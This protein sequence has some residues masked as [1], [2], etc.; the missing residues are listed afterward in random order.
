MAGPAPAAAPE[1]TPAPAPAPARAPAAPA[2]RPKPAPNAAPGNQA[3]QAPAP[4]VALAPVAL[5]GVSDFAPS[6]EV[7]DAITATRSRG[8]P[9]P[10]RLGALAHGDLRVRAAGPSWETTGGTQALTLEHPALAT[11]RAAGLDPVL[12]VRVQRGTVSGYASLRKGDKVLGDPSALTSWI[13][14]HPAELGWVGLTDLRV[15]KVVNTFEGGQLSVRVDELAF[16]LGGYLKGTAAFGLT[17]DGLSLAGS[18][19]LKVGGLAEADLVI[20]R[21][22]AGVL[23]GRI[24]VPVTIAK[25]SGNVVAVFAGGVVDVSGTARYQTEKLSG[26][27]NLV[28]TDQES[29]RT[30]ALRKLDPAT[31]APPGAP[32][33]PAPAAAPEGPRP[34]PRALAGWGEL[35]F[36][37]TE[38]LTGRAK[39]A[40]DNVGHVTVIGE[41]APPSRVELFAQRDIVKRIFLLEIR[42]LYGIPLVGNVFLFA[43]IGL[44]ALAKFGPGVLYDIKVEGQYSTD[45]LIANALSLSAAL[46]I[47][48]FAG[49]RLRAEGGVGVEILS[50]DI[51]AGVGLSALAGVRGYV[52]ARPRIGYREKAAPAEGRTGEFYVQG[53]LELAAQ[54][55]LA[56]SGDFFVEVDAPWWSPVSDDKWTW[57]LG[58]L[59]YP[60]PGQFGIGAKVDY[61]IG[62]PDLPEIEFSAAE[63]SADKFMTDLV[64]DH[65]PKGR[66]GE[67][68][69][70]GTWTEEPEAA[71]APAAAP[72]AAGGAA[73]AGAPGAPAGPATG[74]GPK[75]PKGPKG[76]EAPPS[77]RPVD[78]TAVKAAALGE[79]ERRAGAG[80]LL[81]AADLQRVVGAVY[82]EYAGQGLV[83]LDVDVP[84]EESME[85]VVSARASD[86]ER[87]SITWSEAFAK[88][89]P[90]LA[91]F[92]RAPSFE[93]NALVS[94][95]GAAV[96]STVAS[97]ENGHAEQNLLATAWPKVLQRLA[98]SP[99]EHQVVLAINRAPCHGRCTPALIEAITAVPRSIRDR[100]TFVL[101]PTGT[102]EPT[103]NLTQEQVDAAAE[104][105]EAVRERLG[106]A[107]Q[108][109]EGYRVLS[110]A[111]LKDATTRA[112]DIVDLV[113]A[114]WDVRQLA[115]RSDPTSAQTSLAEFAHKV[116]VQAGKAHAGGAAKAPA[117][118][119]E[120]PAKGKK[121]KPT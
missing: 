35:D 71:P 85:L 99:G 66:T 17:N 114:G 42:T 25:F 56:L 89:T 119:A 100:T 40:I 6:P 80:T 1:R 29:A 109:V 22:P 18:A 11:A 10:V 90:G 87:R 20:A 58:Q 93:T 24:E 52:E 38:W 63:F 115:V 37:F 95:D 28:V 86:P 106:A 105:Y 110:R 14:A 21:D 60:L 84:D 26:E 96:G 33:A 16:T 53:A 61:V 112:S 104:R 27:V 9:V 102:Y 74:P 23:S 7:A 107:G 19:H 50:H 67:Q 55:F 57:P 46:N 81:S 13:R 94:V 44:D 5:D 117:K 73:P 48:A 43:N 97:D 51:K 82:S 113:A 91:M 12:V 75:G 103:N 98:A 54:P 116:A 49:L 118:A 34:G 88:G 68:E 120:A 45:P 30:I 8:L 31:L 79:V 77:G 111:Q 64:N 72:V 92:R 32:G 36:A 39:V 121:P 101:A 59:E 69:K 83:S 2:H 70:Q 65:I 3:A 76:P 41:I 15:P 62:S 47:S 108:Q 4:P 78:P